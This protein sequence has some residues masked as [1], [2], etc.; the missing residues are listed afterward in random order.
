MPAR[1]ATAGRRALAAAAGGLYMSLAL[2]QPGHAGETL[3]GTVEL[4][5]SLGAEVAPSGDLIQMFEATWSDEQWAVHREAARHERLRKKDAEQVHRM[6]SL[7]MWW[8]P[9]LPLLYLEGMLPAEQGA[10]L[11]SALERR[12]EEVVLA[13][14]PDSP[15]E[16]RLAD[17]L[18]EL[19]TGSGGGAAPVP[20]A[21]A[22]VLKSS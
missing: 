3:G 9:E 15:Q 21:P 10:A 20:M 11:K 18:V 19:V 12:P 17:A 13:D 16:A 6:R 8:D 7:S 2:I 14:R 4:V 1:F 5:R 22:V